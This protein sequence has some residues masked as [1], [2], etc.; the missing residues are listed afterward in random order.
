M[1]GINIMRKIIILIIFVMIPIIQVTDC[2]GKQKNRRSLHTVLVRNN[3]L[4]I[5]TCNGGLSY[6]FINR[7]IDKDDLKTESPYSNNQVLKIHSRLLKVFPNPV[8][9]FASFE[10]ELIEDAIVN[11]YTI[12]NLRNKQIHFSGFKDKGIQQIQLNFES[13]NK[14]I[15]FVYLEINNYV[16]FEKVIK[17]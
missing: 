8:D 2:L 3:A 13:M 1:E 14:G 9:R 7:N 5:G 15:V 11:V 16:R 4:S 6:Q 12:D 17:N 10:F